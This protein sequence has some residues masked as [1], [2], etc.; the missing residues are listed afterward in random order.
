MTK[1]FR[2]LWLKITNVSTKAPKDIATCTLA[3]CYDHIQATCS[4]RV[5]KNTDMKNNLETLRSTLP[6][7]IEIYA[8]MV[9]EKISEVAAKK[10]ALIEALVDGYGLMDRVHN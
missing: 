5:A 7:P 2:S 8:R 9:N 1:K 3:N 6:D 10:Q 4:S